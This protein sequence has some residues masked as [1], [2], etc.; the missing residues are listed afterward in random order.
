M[1][2]GTG[3]EGGMMMMRMKTGRGIEGGVMMMMM[4]TK[5]GE[6]GRGK[7]RKGGKKRRCVW[8]ATI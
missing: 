4:K 7:K 8:K 5:I 1:M 3:G 2:R 6:E